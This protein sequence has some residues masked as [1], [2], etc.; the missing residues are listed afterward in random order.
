VQVFT[1]SELTA[2]DVIELGISNV[3]IATG[4]SW[5]RDGV[6]RSN[7]RPL[8]IANTMP[9]MTP[10]HIMAGNI[11]ENGPIVIYDDD[12]IYIGGVLAEHLAAAGHKMIFITPASMVSPWTELTLE[13]K[14]IQK[15]LIELGVTI[16]TGQVLTAINATSCKLACTYSGQSQEIQCGAAL[17][18][19][20][21]TRNT[22][23]Y[24]ALKTKATK[25]QT[26]EL[27]GDAS[28]P[29]L[30]ADAVYAGHMAARNFEE[31]PEKVAQQFF[32]R[33]IIPLQNE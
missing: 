24:D 32:R 33:E 10:D 11:P 7:R 14:R 3:F 29:G 2:A 13:Q 5:R 6:G 4:A 17:L 16:H 30:I 28:A 9:V 18:V 27:I 25:L 12:Q 26:I 20:E 15:S 1:E 23:L 22:S 8:E 19:T 21:R 31:D